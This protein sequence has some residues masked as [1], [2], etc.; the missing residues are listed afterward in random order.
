CFALL[1]WSCFPTCTQLILLVPPF[2]F[3]H[4][5]WLSGQQCREKATVSESHRQLWWEG[6]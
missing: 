4:S 3:L 5:E 1:D 2:L 6:Q